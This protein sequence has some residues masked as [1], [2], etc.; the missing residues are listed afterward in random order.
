MWIPVNCHQCRFSSIVITV[1]SLQLSSL[2]FLVNC[3]HSCF[4]SIVITLVFC[5]FSSLSFL[6]NCHH[7]RFL[8]IFITL[9]SCQFSS[10]SLHVNC[11]QCRHFSVTNCHHS[12]NYSRSCWTRI[13]VTRCHISLVITAVCFWNMSSFIFDPCHHGILYT[14]ANKGWR[15][16][17]N[18]KQSAVFCPLTS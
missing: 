18:L 11:H 2:S 14:M 5:Q 15:R 16:A 17:P 7:S 1:V 10:L 9:V 4:L 3:H 8:S 12:T 13:S 6:A